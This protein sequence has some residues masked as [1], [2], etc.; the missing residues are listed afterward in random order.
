MADWPIEKPWGYTAHNFEAVKEN[1]ELMWNA[2]VRET[3]A[4]KRDTAA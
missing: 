2:W 1:Y 4:R 3:A